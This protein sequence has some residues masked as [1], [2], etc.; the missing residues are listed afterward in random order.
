MLEDDAPLIASCV[1]DHGQ[2]IGLR[3]GCGTIVR[4]HGQCVVA[5]E[6]AI[7]RLE[8]ELPWLKHLALIAH[9]AVLHGQ[10]R[11]GQL[12]RY[13]I[14]VNRAPLGIPDFAVDGWDTVFGVALVLVGLLY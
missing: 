8:L 12:D 6:L 5:E 1:R 9:R 14:A 7:W 11:G 2:R 13:K 4:D 10:H 3:K